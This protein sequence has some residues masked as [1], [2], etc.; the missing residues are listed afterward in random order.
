MLS[1]AAW[2]Y[3]RNFAWESEETLWGDV[4]KKYPEIARS[5]QYVAMSLAAS[6]GKVKSY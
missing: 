3:Q 6:G 1:L 2:T 5:Y 4:A